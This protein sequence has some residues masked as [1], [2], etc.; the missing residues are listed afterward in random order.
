MTC[1]RGFGFAVVILLACNGTAS[2]N[3]GS[4]GILS[5]ANTLARQ[6]DSWREFAILAESPDCGLA[7]RQQ[8]SELSSVDQCGGV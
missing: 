4:H 5:P 8:A 1:Y 2:V 6:R 7:H 3:P